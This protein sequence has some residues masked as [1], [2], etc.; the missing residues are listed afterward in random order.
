MSYQRKCAYCGLE[1]EHDRK[2]IYCSAECAAKAKNE[3]R[4]KWEPERVVY[5]K[6]CKSC[7][8]PFL[9]KDFRRR[10]CPECRNGTTIYFKKH[11]STIDQVA[12]QA[13]AAGTS[14]GKMM[15]SK[16]IKDGSHNGRTCCGLHAPHEAGDC[17]PELQMPGQ[18]R[19]VRVERQGHGG[20]EA[21]AARPAEER[22]SEEADRRD[23]L[24]V[25]PGEDQP[26]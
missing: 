23:P 21:Q 16:Y 15:A 3:M 25:L 8:E 12:K 26:E 9:A 18:L 10:I 4:R 13:R 2:R 1:F 19:A 11:V 7:G 5:S 17:E 20:A 24:P 22:R 14:Y 6:V